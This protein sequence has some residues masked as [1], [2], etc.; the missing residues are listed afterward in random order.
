MK[1]PI[2][3][4]LTTKGRYMTTLPLCL[5]SILNQT[6]LPSSIM[7]VDDNEQKDFYNYQIFKNIIT[8]CKLKNI[9]FQYYHGQSK[10][11]VLAQQLLFQKTKEEWIFK[12]DDDNILETNVLELLS[13][14]IDTNV[15]ALSGLILS[16]KDFKSNRK[17]EYTS[18]I[19]NKVCDIY[20]YF[21]I[22]MC[23]NQDNSLKRVEHIYSNYLFRKELIDRYPLEFAPAGHREDTVTTHSIHRKGYKLFINP[24]AII[25]HLND[26]EGGNRNYDYNY[27]IKNEKLFL[28]KLNDWGI[29]LNIKE[30]EKRVY[31]IRD[32]KDWL[33]YEK[34]R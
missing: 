32:G 17:I 8:L 21:N 1:L 28:G 7:I 14:N 10:G 6:M 33:I 9:N 22:Q 5:M 15:G 13:K 27:N 34:N 31:E 25:W 4:N 2:S 24:N 30:D 23:R 19:Y 26:T 20:R 29:H 16:K 12:I 3:V 18:E 11:Q